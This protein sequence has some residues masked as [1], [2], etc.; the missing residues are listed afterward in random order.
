MFSTFLSYSHAELILERGIAL[1]QGNPNYIEGS[2][3]Y[4]AEEFFFAACELQQMEWA[5]FFL[6]MIR[7]QFPKSIKSMRMLAVYYE[8]NGQC[9]K[10][11]AILEDIIEGNPSDT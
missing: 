7:N 1:V 9:D 2:N 6:H 10:A 8:A 3:M 11:K 5:A 4:L